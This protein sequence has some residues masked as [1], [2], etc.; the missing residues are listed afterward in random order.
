MGG[1]DSEITDTSTN[2]LIESAYFSPGSVRKTARTLGIHSDASYRFERGIDYGNVLYVADLAAKMIV[3]LGGGSIVNGTVDEYPKPIQQVK[4]DLNLEYVSRLL[5]EDITGEKIIEILKGLDFE[6][7]GNADSGNIAVTS[8][9]WRVDINKPIDLVEEVARVYGYDNLPNS[10]SPSINFSE[11]GT[12]DL[13]A[14]PQARAEVRDL[15]I[16]F[17][18]METMHPNQVDPEAMA[19]YGNDPVELKNPL[20]ADFASMRTSLIHSMLKTVAHNNNQGNQSLRLF[21]IGKVF[22]ATG[23]Q[24]SFVQGYTEQDAICVALC[25]NNTAHWSSKNSPYD[26]YDIKGLLEA[27]MAELNISKVK[28]KQSRDISYPLSADSLDVYVGKSKVGRVGAISKSAK[29][30]YDLDKDV[31]LLE[32]DLSGLYFHINDKD[33]YQKV[34]P[35]PTMKRD[36]AFVVDKDVTAGKLLNIAEQNGGKYMQNVDIFDVYEGENLDGRKSL[37][38][39]IHF[40]SKD[41]TLTDEEIKTATDKIINTAQKQLNAELRG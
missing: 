37:A 15:M 7:N 1:L 24:S 34:S 6:V 17:G 18:Y 22:F 27:L 21:E 23:S 3:D 29:K 13:L 30:D 20:G 9:T 5:G 31:F 8:P 41:K 12:P 4:V 2:V 25:G 38:L 14:M 39:A 16:G 26:F 35:Y 40:G 19:K 33:S 36:L 28:I 32:L 10:L 11:L